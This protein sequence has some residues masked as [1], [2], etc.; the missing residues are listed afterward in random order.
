LT[1]RRSPGPTAAPT[2]SLA[3]AEAHEDPSGTGTVGTRKAPDE[4]GGWIAVAI[5]WITVATALLLYAR[6]LRRAARAAA[7]AAE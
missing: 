4:T 2:L 3:I 1:L 7:K 6:R 5:T